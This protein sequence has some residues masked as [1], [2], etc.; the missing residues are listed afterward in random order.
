[1]YYD[2]FMRNPYNDNNLKNITMDI[3]KFTEYKGSEPNITY[4]LLGNERS[5]H[6]IRDEIKSYI[7]ITS[8]PKLPPTDILA[9]IIHECMHI[10]KEYNKIEY[11]SGYSQ[12][13][14]ADTIAIYLGFYENLSI[15][16]KFYTSQRDLDYILRKINL[17]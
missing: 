3:L 16:Y 15:A 11:P 13:L 9:L 4:T 17:Q 14:I 2:A 7:Q 10:Y 1:M 8:E 6:F 12:E 5:K